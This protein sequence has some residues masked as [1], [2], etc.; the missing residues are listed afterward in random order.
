MILQPDR[1]LVGGDF[2]SG[3]A[4]TVEG[5]RIAAVGPAP[6]V[7]RRLPGCA[8]VP[9]LVN[10][11][12]HAFQRVLRGRTEHRVTGRDDFWSWRERMYQ[13][14][15]ALTPEEM[16]AV[17][18]LAFVEMAL[19]GIT[20]V[21][22]FHYLHHQPGG[23]PYADPDEMAWR[24]LAAAE[25]AGLTAVLLRAGYA[26]AGYGR[27]PTPRQARFADASP[28]AVIQAVERLR[29]RGARV[30]VAP[31]SVRACP[32]PWIRELAE[33]ARSEGLPFHMHVAEQPREV[34]E[35]RA[36]HGVPPVRLLAREG[37]L[38]EGFTA[39][40][41]IHL[42]PDEVQDLGAAGATVCCC[43]T[44]ERN[45]GDGVVPADRLLAAGCRLVLG[46]D[47]QCQVNLLEDARQLDY[48]LRLLHRERAV[49]DRPSGSLAERLFAC[50]TR[51]GARCLGLEAGAIAPGRPA[52]L[53][54]VSLDDPSIAGA[55]PEDLL[56]SLVF[57]LERPA[58]RHVW[59][60]GRLIVE[61]GRHFLQE[62]A[63]RDFARVMKRLG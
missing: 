16:E 15:A 29:A 21:G 13:A 41:A 57:A 44:T 61:E 42:E 30:G 51:E 18:R 12:S 22:E 27:G 25:A 2:V 5:E 53:V 19:A 63:V 43:P 7:A 40:H 9:G 33:Y 58:V 26:R 17:S 3:V 34:E 38:A 1:V 4:V 59:A 36:E 48:H 60:R 20:S 52:D 32:L 24:V 23:A 35:C 6:E 37:L 11:H 50:A 54:A 8:L 10:A 62:E 56:S 55:G 47:S 49:L 31:H 39:I 45:L 28:Q 46:T 14:A